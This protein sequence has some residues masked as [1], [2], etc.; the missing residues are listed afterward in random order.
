VRTCLP[1][2]LAPEER[3]YFWLGITVN[4]LAERAVVTGV[5]KDSPAAKAGLQA[6]DTIVK[7]NDHEVRDPVDWELILLQARCG[8]LWPMTLLRGDKRIEVTMAPA[9]YPRPKLEDQAGKLKGLKYDFY[10]LAHLRKMPDFASLKPSK[11]GVAASLDPV[12]IAG[13]GKENYAIAFEGFIKLSEKGLRRLVLSSDD[14]SRLYLDDRLVV[15]NVGPHAL[16][17]SSGPINVLP[18]LHR[19][20]IEYFNGADGAGLKLY[21]RGSDGQQREILG[22]ELFHGTE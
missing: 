19:L 9:E 22:S 10:Q 13:G 15:D 6:G 8:Q 11:S 2:L 16:Q 20:R 5:A 17:D 4:M 21:L 7:A 18:G 3:F 1:D 12:A 14:G